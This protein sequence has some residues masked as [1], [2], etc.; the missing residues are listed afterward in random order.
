MI[1]LIVPLLC[2]IGVGMA[3]TGI[4]VMHNSSISINKRV[5][6]TATGTFLYLAGFALLFP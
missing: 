6:L 2:V 3:F 1:R 4:V 5:L